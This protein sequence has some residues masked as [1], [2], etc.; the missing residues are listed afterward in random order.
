[1]GSPKVGES[2]AG[3]PSD[4]ALMVGAV[5]N[6]RVDKPATIA[7]SMLTDGRQPDD[8]SEDLARA[9]AQGQQGVLLVDWR[10]RE[11][12]RQP[13]LAEALTGN[14]DL[15]ALT[16]RVPG[17]FSRMEIG[18]ETAG[19]GAPLRHGPD[20]LDVGAGHLAVRVGHRPAAAPPTRPSAG[21]WSGP[22]ATGSRW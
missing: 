21:P 9:L 14:Q 2:V 8:F 19:R 10:E 1:M 5:M 6:R 13:G 15:T 11:P 16:R 22:A 18:Q 17:G 12:S 20:G 7:V 3:S 4:A